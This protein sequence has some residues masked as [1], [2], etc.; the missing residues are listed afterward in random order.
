MWD[1][2]S[3]YEV[4][5]CPLVSGGYRFLLRPPLP[6]KACPIH[7]TAC[8]G[9]GILVLRVKRIVFVALFRVDQVKVSDIVALIS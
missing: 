5:D 3:F 4:V 9:G 2:T 1:A 8:R 7:P 6:L